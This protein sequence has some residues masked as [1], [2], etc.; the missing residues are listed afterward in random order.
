MAE[1]HG[2]WTKEQYEEQG[3]PRINPVVKK[4]FSP[5][6]VDMALKFV[7]AGG[8][9]KDF[10]FVIGTNQDVLREWKKDHPEFKHAIKKAKKLTQSR[11]IGAGIRAAEGYV[12]NDTTVT[13]QHE[14]LA[15]GTIGGLVPGSK[16]EVKKFTKTIPPDNKLLQ[17]IVSAISRQLGNDDWLNKQFTE[18]KVSGQ[19]DHVIDATAIAKQI[20]AQAGGLTKKIS[21]NVID[22][23]IQD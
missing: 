23:E 12:I 7:G 5:E 9:E 14:V 15:D 1:T 10:A 13:E 4:A 2:R 18:T 6:Y 22:A 17:F 16:V 3:A 11:L 19:V 8:T 21:S 20:E